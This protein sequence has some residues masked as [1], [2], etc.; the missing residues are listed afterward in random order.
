LF[1]E[2]SRLKL[3]KSK[4]KEPVEEEDGRGFSPTT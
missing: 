4:S 3:K 1:E 2:H